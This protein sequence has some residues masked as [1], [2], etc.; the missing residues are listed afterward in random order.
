VTFRNARFKFEISALNDGDV[1]G[2]R[3]FLAL[4]DV[5]RHFVSFI[6]G[7]EPGGVDPGIMN[8]YIR[9]FFLLDKSI[10]LAAIKPFYNACS[11]SDTL[12]S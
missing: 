10:P 7:F 9:P 1:D 3:P 12:L 5:E 11:H 2:S 4:L 8:E 6:Q